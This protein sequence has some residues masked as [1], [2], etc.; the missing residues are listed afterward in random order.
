VELLDAG[1]PVDV[2]ILG[3]FHCIGTPRGNHRRTGSD[4]S[5]AKG[6]GGELLG[7]AKQP[8]QFVEV[9]LS[10]GNFGSYHIDSVFWVFK[11][12]KHLFQLTID[13]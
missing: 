2:H 12:E 3:N 8:F 9:G 1:N 13:N 11:E 10:K 5:T 6:R 7:I 4:E